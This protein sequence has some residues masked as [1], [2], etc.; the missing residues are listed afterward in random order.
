[1]TGVP[2]CSEEQWEKEEAERY[3]EARKRQIAK[4]KE[5]N[6]QKNKN[7]TMVA[8]VNFEKYR[9]SDA[10][11]LVVKGVKQI[12][13]R[14]AV[15]YSIPKDLCLVYYKDGYLVVERRGEDDK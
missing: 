15:K 11:F 8:R 14:E 6:K 12:P 2:N 4:N 13:M 3:A 7:T 10:F 5:R 9:D 1:M